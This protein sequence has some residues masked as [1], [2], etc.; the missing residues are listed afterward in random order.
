[1]WRA[2]PRTLRPVKELDTS[3]VDK[4]TNWRVAAHGEITMLH[5]RGTKSVHVFKQDTWLTELKVQQM[6]GN[7]R[8]M[9]LTD[10][11]LLV[12]D[13]IEHNLRAFSWSAN[14]PVIGDVIWGPVEAWWGALRV[15]VQPPSCG[16]R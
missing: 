13:Y 3:K 7:V 9:V 14:P 2:D 11:E 10:T 4:S 12:G 15:A 1:M 16:Q 5:V 6:P 8:K